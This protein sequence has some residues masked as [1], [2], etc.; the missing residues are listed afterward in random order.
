MNKDVL[1][2]RKRVERLEAL[3][4][5]DRERPGERLVRA[6]AGGGQGPIKVGETKVELGTPGRVNFGEVTA[7]DDEGLWWW[8]TAAVASR[9]N[10]DWVKLSVGIITATTKALLGSPLL[11][12]FGD[13]TADGN[14][15][16]LW[17]WN[18][19]T[20][21]R[22]NGALGT[23]MVI[24]TV[25]DL[26]PIPSSGWRVVHWTSE[27]DGNGDDQHW[28][29]DETDTVWRPYGGKFTALAGTPGE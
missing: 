4:G 13:V 22:V 11:K 15:N 3:L 18:L 19:S 1:E 12:T 6:A 14:N 26:P 5:D 8:D 20:W 27:D 10:D 28:F 23:V 2:L 17:F 21:E 29:A 25:Q 16:G 9:D 24:P 7:G